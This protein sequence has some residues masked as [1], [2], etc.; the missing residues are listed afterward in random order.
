[1]SSLLFNI[2]LA[3][4]ELNEKENGNNLDLQLFRNISYY[5]VGSNWTHRY[6]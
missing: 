1:M 4:I 6:Y 2:V 5:G 3:A